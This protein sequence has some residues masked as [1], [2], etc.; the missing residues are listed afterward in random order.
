MIA[1]EG[2]DREAF[3]QGQVT[4]DVRALSA[5]KASAAALCDIKGRV[6]ATFILMK[7]ED[8]YYL[9][10]PLENLSNTLSRLKKYALFSKVT[11]SDVSSHWYFSA[12]EKPTPPS[13]EILTLH[14]QGFVSSLTLPGDHAR[15]LLLSQD[16]TLLET[17]ADEKSK[18]GFTEDSEAAWQLANIKARWASILPATTALF[19]PQMLALEKQGGVSFSKGCYLGQEIIARTEHLGKL[20]RHLYL[21]EFSAGLLIK[22]GD[23]IETAAHEEVGTLINVQFNHALAVIEDRAIEAGALFVAEVPIKVM[24]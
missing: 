13:A 6:Q 14:Q 19:T 15:L 10:V 1:V 3:L 12:V 7:Q 2:L 18:A 17:A 21:I 11:L 9:I 23:W 8:R 4:A 20:K 22:P 5:T 16:Q 24:G